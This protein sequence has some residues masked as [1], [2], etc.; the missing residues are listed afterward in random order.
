MPT[1]LAPF[2]SMKEAGQHYGLKQLKLNYHI[3]HGQ[4]LLGRGNFGKVYLSQSLHDPN[5]KVAIKVIDKLFL[6]VIANEIE[7]LIRLD[8]PNIVRFF[9][10]YNAQSY[11][12]LVSQYCGGRNLLEHMD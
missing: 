12:Y 8:H 5:L 1:T 6:N 9:E 11:I 4:I 3:G 7:T 2:R 10:C